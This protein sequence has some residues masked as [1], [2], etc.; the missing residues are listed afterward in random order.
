MSPSARL[1]TVSFRCLLD[2]AHSHEL[3]CSAC[4]P[5]TGASNLSLPNGE[6]RGLAVVFPVSPARLVFQEVVEAQLPVE[7][8]RDVPVIQGDQLL[9]HEEP[10]SHVVRRARGGAAAAGPVGVEELAARLVEPL[11][12]VRPEVVALGL[13]QVRRQPAGAVAV[14][15]RQAPTPSPAAGCRWS[16]PAPTTRRQPLCARPSSPAKY[17]STSRFTSFGLRSNA[18]LILPRNALR[19]MHPPRHISAIP[20]LFSSHLLAFACA[21]IRA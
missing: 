15:V 12:G 7:R 11:V 10:R 5:T 19:M 20:P 9:V 18:S 2:H 13:Q 17:G 21:A 1:V 4:E 6:G 3:L 8:R 16:P 14:V